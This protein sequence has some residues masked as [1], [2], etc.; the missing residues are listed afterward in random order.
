MY[1]SKRN[2]LKK[3][4]PGLKPQNCLLTLQFHLKSED[5]RT[6]DICLPWLGRSESIWKECWLIERLLNSFPWFSQERKPYSNTSAASDQLTEYQVVLSPPPPSAYD[7][8]RNQRQK[9]LYFC[10]HVRAFQGVDYWSV[11]PDVD[12]SV[13][14]CSREI[15]VVYTWALF[16]G[17]QAGSV[18]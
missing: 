5:Y 8:W 17:M 1:L 15:G 10:D 9:D 2:F 12:T 3:P 11:P 14:F 18:R 6:H 7:T 16:W 4:L 13:Q